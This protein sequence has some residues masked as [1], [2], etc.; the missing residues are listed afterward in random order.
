MCELEGEAM[1]DA[2]AAARAAKTTMDVVD[3]FF[4]PSLERAR[5]QADKIHRAWLACQHVDADGEAK[6]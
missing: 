1:R 2:E 3:A 5:R 4:G 6:P